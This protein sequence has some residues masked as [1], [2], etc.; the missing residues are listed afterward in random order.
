MDQCHWPTRCE[1]ARVENHCPHTPAPR[2]QT[3][4]LRPWPNPST[5]CKRTLP[6]LSASTACCWHQICAVL[7]MCVEENMQDHHPHHRMAH[8]LNHASWPCTTCTTRCVHTGAHPL[9]SPASQSSHPNHQKC[10]VPGSSPAGCID[11]PPPLPFDAPRTRHRRSEPSTA[12]AHALQTPSAVGERRPHPRSPCQTAA[13]AWPVS[14]SSSSSVYRPPA[15]PLPPLRPGREGK[16]PALA[17][18]AHGLAA[19]TCRPHQCQ[20]LTLLCFG[21]E[22]GRGEEEEGGVEVGG[23]PSALG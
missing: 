13:N 23:K 5:V 11:C 18:P 21:V 3:P 19:I 12:S 6:T 14:R 15:P 9:P 22:E 7:T 1:R 2:F 10:L 4:S 20:A 16:T 8:N 17:P